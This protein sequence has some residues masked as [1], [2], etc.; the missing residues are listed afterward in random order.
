[1]NSASGVGKTS[2]KRGKDEEKLGRRAGGKARGILGS[3][4]SMFQ[5]SG[6]DGVGEEA[7]LC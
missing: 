6:G 5:K 1:M 3:E 4:N 2:S 7:N